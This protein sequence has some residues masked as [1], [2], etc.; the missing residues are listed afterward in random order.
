MGVVV[1]LG[2]IADAFN[3][4]ALVVAA[5]WTNAVRYHGLAA[6]GAGDEVGGGDFVVVCTAHVTLRTGCSSLGYGHG[7]ARF[8]GFGA[9]LCRV[10]WA[11]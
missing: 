7:V 6:V 8:F 3:L 9:G 1:L 4:G 2:A 11:S 5:G 10:S